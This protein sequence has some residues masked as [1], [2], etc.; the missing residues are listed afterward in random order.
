MPVATILFGYFPGKRLGLVG[1]LPKQVMYQWR[2]W[3]LHPDY[4]V[5]MESESVKTK[6]QKIDVPLVS[7]NFTDDEMLKITNMRDLHALFGH[8]NKALKDLNPKDLDEKHIGHL[9]FFREKFKHTLWPKLLLSE[10][11]QI[12]QV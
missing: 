10:L 5:G 8:Q 3:C 1:D 11:S 6:F 7:I 4:C 12:T 9:G 2:R